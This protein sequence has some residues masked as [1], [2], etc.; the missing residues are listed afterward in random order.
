MI[1]AVIQPSYIPWRGYFEFIK[2]ADLFVFYDDVQYDKHGWRNRNQ[3]FGPAGKQWLTI[4]VSTKGNISEQI[5]INQVK[6]NWNTKWAKKHLNC[7]RSVYGKAPHF[8]TYEPLLEE[9]YARKDVLL[10]DFTIDFTKAIAKELGI[11]NTEYVLS[12]TLSSS[13]A[14]T[15]RLLQVLKQVGCTHYLSGPTA[16]DYLDEALLEKEGITWEYMTYNYPE[17]PQLKEP[18]NGSLSILDLLFM[19][20]PN[21]SDYFQACNPISPADS[22]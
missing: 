18:F 1:T 5:P 15:E 8:R 19:A 2:R 10:S 14:K 6:I 11:D 17:Y 20:G 9:Y 13:G 12:S 4:P 7:L 21:A 3:V 16:K 22:V